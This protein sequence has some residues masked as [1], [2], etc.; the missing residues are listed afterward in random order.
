M[1][2]IYGLTSTTPTEVSQLTR[3]TLHMGKIVTIDATAGACVRG[4]IMAQITATMKWV[5]LDHDGAGGAEVARGILGIIE[6]ETFTADKERYMF[7]AGEYNLADVTFDTG[8]DAAE[9]A[10]CLQQLE[11]RGILV[12]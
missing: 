7:M 5:P 8:M 6:P 4:Q 12:A 1:A 9:K 3:S 10:T 11:D 2:G